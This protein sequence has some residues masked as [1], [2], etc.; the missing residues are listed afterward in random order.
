MSTTNE[1]E[2]RNPKNKKDKRIKNVRRKI[3]YLMN[4]LIGQDDTTMESLTISDLVAG[5]WLKHN[6]FYIVFVTILILIYTG[7]RYA[8]QQEQIETKRLQDELIDIRFKLLTTN[9]ELRKHSRASILEE[10]LK[11]S[12]LRPSITPNFKLVRDGLSEEQN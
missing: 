5:E 7:N 9:S 10:H 12:T 6:W 4:D 8:C 1:Q 11:D 2:I 3:D